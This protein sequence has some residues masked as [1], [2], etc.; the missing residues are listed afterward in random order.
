MN[1]V[2]IRIAGFG[3]QGVILAGMIIGRA[4]ALYDGKDATLTQSFGPEAR[5][6]A[7]SAQLVISDTRNL[8]P[9]LVRPDIL[10]T[11]SQPAFDKFAGELKPEGLLLFESS[12]VK[13]TENIEVQRTYGI[14][15]SKIAEGMGRHMVLNI[16]MLGFFTA[17]SRVVGK[18]A[19]EKAIADAV[20][21]GTT[22]LN[23]DAFKRGFDYGLAVAEGRDPEVESD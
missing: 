6:G 22:R 23:L 20:P 5:G 18:E 2:E 9:C 19:M 10:V 15:A 16:V 3:G 21:P 17:L 11:M 14:P 4:A 12:L 13:P 8:Y 1:R 7:C